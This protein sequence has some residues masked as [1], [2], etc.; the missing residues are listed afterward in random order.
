MKHGIKLITSLSAALL[1]AS[2]LLAVNDG[3]PPSTP[4]DSPYNAI[5]LRNV[6]D[7]KPKPD[8]SLNAAPEAPPTPP[9]N[10]QLTGIMTILGTKQALF[11]VQ[12]RPE[13]GK[14]PGSPHSYI[15]K[16]GER[17]DMLEVLEIH[18]K[19]HNVK[20]K[21]DDL[22]TTITFE[23]NKPAGG[24]GVLPGGAPGMPAMPGM[25]MNR[26]GMPPGGVPIPPRIPRNPNYSPAPGGAYNQSPA[27]PGYS[28]Q[29]YGANVAYSPGIPALNAAN[30]GG[31]AGTAAAIS[32]G[33]FD[34]ATGHLNV[35]AP[36]VTMTPEEQMAAVA[37]QH[38]LHDQEIANGTYPPLP[39]IPGMPEPGNNNQNNE[40]ATGNTGNNTSVPTPPQPTIPSWAGSKTTGSY[41]P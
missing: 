5:W 27:Q 23:T 24:P 15:L 36:N 9:P 35:P 8:P 7:L 2:S 33:L 25:P 1:T 12:P 18:P 38:Q 19:E 29:S 22:V 34:P 6:F 17:R 31:N 32:S 37:V 14:P 10:V 26:P 41:K 20:I 16:E 13:A 3:D 11:M 30:T 39:P 28:P 40:S 4:G 21:V